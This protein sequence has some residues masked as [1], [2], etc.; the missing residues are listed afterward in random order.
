[1]PAVSQTSFGAA[2]IILSRGR[3]CNP[4]EK[5]AGSGLVVHVF[6]STLPLFAVIAGSYWWRMKLNQP[7]VY[8]RYVQSGF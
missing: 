2:T 5:G 1:M 3:C 8:L 7:L 6:L 4:I